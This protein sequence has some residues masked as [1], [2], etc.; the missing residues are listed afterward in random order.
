MPNVVTRLPRLLTGLNNNIQKLFSYQKTA[1]AFILILSGCVNTSTIMRSWQGRHIED[2]IMNWGAP[3]SHV[4]LESGRTVYSWISNWGSA[5]MMNTCR[6]SFTADKSG[7]ILNWRF[8]GCP[9]WQSNTSTQ[10]WFKPDP[11][12]E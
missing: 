6:Q 9:Q 12:E 2:L 8:S 1:L 10:D 4:K 3:S 7:F 5:Y 11:V